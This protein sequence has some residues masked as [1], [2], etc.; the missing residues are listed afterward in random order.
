MITNAGSDEKIYPGNEFWAVYT[1]T[2]SSIC[3]QRS[4]LIQSLSFDLRAL[5]MAGSR[6]GARKYD[7]DEGRG[8]RSHCAVS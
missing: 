8:G 3:G 1:V 4:T 2:V 6:S 5:F 7:S